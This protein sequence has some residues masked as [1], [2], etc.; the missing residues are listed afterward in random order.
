MDYH[1]FDPKKVDKALQQSGLRKAY[2]NLRIDN[3]QKRLKHGKE[4][5]LEELHLTD[6]VVVRDAEEK[7]YTLMGE[8]Y[9]LNDNFRGSAEA[10][11]IREKYRPLIE[12]YG[13]KEFYFTYGVVDFARQIA[14]EYRAPTGYVTF[15]EFFNNFE[16]KMTALGCDATASR[17]F[18]QEVERKLQKAAGDNS[19]L[20][21]KFN[22][23]D[24]YWLQDEQLVEAVNLH[25][26]NLYI[27]RESDEVLT[28]STAI[29]AS[30]DFEKTTDNLET[31]IKLRTDQ[32]KATKVS[33]KVGRGSD[34]VQ[35]DHSS[36]PRNARKKS[37]ESGEPEAVHEEDPQPNSWQ[38]KLG[39]GAL[40]TALM[41]APALLPA[42]KDEKITFGKVVRTTITWVAPVVGIFLLARLMP[43]GFTDR[44]QNE[45]PSQ[46]RGFKR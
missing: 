5:F 43:G 40:G 8:N 36:S 32:V 25:Y 30:S 12:T 26:Q 4:A 39:Y 21:L 6:L 38:K 24:T 44:V 11:K 10:K 46:G 9:P 34:T 23:S 14:G 27:A 3:I 33:Q 1:G 19:P 17:H 41:V 37:G 13:K 42:E 31:L 29:F 45:A 7:F 35:Q 2:E 16:D 28:I 18:V 20:Q 15:S 22:P